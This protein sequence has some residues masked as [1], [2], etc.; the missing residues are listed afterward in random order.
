MTSLGRSMAN[1]S[2]P[3]IKALGLAILAEMPNIR[4]FLAQ[5]TADNAGQLD[6]I[7]VKAYD[8]KVPGR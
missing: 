2:D 5:Q 6:R 3:D 1:S 4:Y 8:M 7:V